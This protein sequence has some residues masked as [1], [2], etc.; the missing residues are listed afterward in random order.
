MGPEVSN[1]YW[2]V[3]VGDSPHDEDLVCGKFGSIAEALQATEKYSTD[4]ASFKFVKFND[5]VSF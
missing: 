2:E 1:G 3:E 5:P 4:Y